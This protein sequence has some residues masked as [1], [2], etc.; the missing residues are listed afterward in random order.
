M[1]RRD[2]GV[3]R[4]A[5]GPSLI[6]DARTGRLIHQW[7]FVDRFRCADLD[8][9]GQPEAIALGPRRLTRSSSGGSWTGS[10]APTSTTTA[11]PRRSRWARAA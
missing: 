2:G 10:A 11:S 3:S 8:D 5:K 9:D 6:L 7:W 1:T 4:Q